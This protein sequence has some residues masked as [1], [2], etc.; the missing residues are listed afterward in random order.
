MC[1]KKRVVVL[2]EVLE[3]E[4]KKRF[5]E[6]TSRI[7]LELSVALWARNG[8]ADLFLGGAKMCFLGNVKIRVV[9]TLPGEEG[10]WLAILRNLPANF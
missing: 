3:E 2:F 7:S 5:M 1:R 4:E 8:L 9:G 10:E 6:R